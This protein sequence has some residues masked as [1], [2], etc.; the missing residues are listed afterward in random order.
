MP[1]HKSRDELYGN[2]PFPDNITRTIY[3]SWDDLYGRDRVEIEQFQLSSLQPRTE[4]LSRESPRSKGKCT[5][6]GSMPSGPWTLPLSFS[7]NTQLTKPTQQLL[8]SGASLYQRD[9]HQSVL[10]RLGVQRCDVP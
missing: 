3:K 2:S 7:S 10:S 5:S 4:E 9:Q 8:W 6:L 1:N